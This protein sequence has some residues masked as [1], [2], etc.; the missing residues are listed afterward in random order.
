LSK[1]DNIRLKVIEKVSEA[2]MFASEAVA[3]LSQ[4]LNYASRG[5]FSLY[6]KPTRKAIENLEVALKIL[7]GRGE[8]V[9]C[10]PETA[11]G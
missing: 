9:E 7:K 5:L 2:Q 11:G 4:S 3:F 8:A 6:V 10:F 1:E